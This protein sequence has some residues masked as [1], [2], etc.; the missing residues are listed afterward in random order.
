MQA[1]VFLLCHTVSLR[2]ITE[3]RERWEAGFWVL[4]L[5]LTGLRP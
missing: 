3:A 2:E 4:P 1:G 5:P